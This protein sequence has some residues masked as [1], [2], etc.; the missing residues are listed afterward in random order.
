MINRFPETIRSAAILAPAAQPDRKLLKNAAARLKK[1]GLEIRIYPGSRLEAHGASLPVP[2]EIRYT[3]F[4]N[5]VKNPETDIIIP[6]RGGFGSA[7]ILPH[8]DWNTLKKR[9]IPV[10]GYSDI[11]ALHLAMLKNNAGLPIHSVT[12]SDFRKE[13]PD[14]NTLESLFNALSDKPRQFRQKLKYIKPGTASGRAIPANLAVLMSITGTPWMPDMKNAILILEDV[15]EP[16]YRIERAFTQ[17]RQAGI[18]QQLAG[19]VLGRFTRC[20]NKNER[21]HVFSKFAESVPGPVL[22]EL[23]FGHGFPRTCV[24]TGANAAIDSKGFLTL[25]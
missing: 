8:I 18:L 25:L 15:N 17:L 2:A 10:L 1:M 5:A 12:A 7:Q 6:A 11:T 20:G 3:D 16:A 13:L 22:H 14:K 24:K 19:L 21:M 9:N 4:N 23:P